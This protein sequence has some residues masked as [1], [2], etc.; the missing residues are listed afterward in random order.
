MRTIE[1]TATFDALEPFLEEL[2]AVSDATDCLI[3]AVDARYIAGEAH[4]RKALE[5]TRA[6]IDDGRQI[7]EDP[8]IEL[9]LAIAGTRQID[10]ALELGIGI[11]EAAIIVIDGDREAAAE[12]QLEAVLTP[13]DRPITPDANRIRDWFGITEAELE[14]TTADLEAVVCERI[15]LLALER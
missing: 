1:G 5:V 3:Q 2:A 7:A 9:L 12:G 13:R 6:A 14:A 11:G 8:S 10:R 15:A 4:L